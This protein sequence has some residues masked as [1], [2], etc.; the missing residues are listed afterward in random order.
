M[1]QLDTLTFWLKPQLNHL[2]STLISKKT[3]QRYPELCCSAQPWLYCRFRNCSMMSRHVSPMAPN[4]LSP[5]VAPWTSTAVN[6]K[7]ILLEDVAHG[8]DLHTSIDEMQAAFGFT[9]K[10]IIRIVLAEF[11]NE[12]VTQPIAVIAQWVQIRDWLKLRLTHMLTLELRPLF[13]AWFGW[14]RGHRKYRAYQASRA[15]AHA[16]MAALRLQI[17]QGSRQHQANME[18]SWATWNH[19]ENLEIQNTSIEDK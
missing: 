7:D 13:Q 5:G 9:Q 16:D 14:Q 15:K 6:W 2:V 11:E 19:H 18:V 1:W 8:V 17:A 3:S 12:E 10:K 4:G